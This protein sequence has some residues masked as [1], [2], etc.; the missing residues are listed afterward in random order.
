V[1]L[2]ASPIT[3]AAYDSGMQQAGT[4]RD[5]PPLDRWLL[6]AAETA[7]LADRLVGGEAAVVNSAVRELVAR[8]LIR[9]DDTHSDRHQHSMRRVRPGAADADA[10]TSQPLDALLGVFATAVKRY[11]ADGVTIRRFAALIGDR[12]ARHGFVYEEVE[13]YLEK[14]GLVTSEQVRLLGIGLWSRAALTEPGRTTCSL[15]DAWLDLFASGPPADQQTRLALLD[16][17]GSVPILFATGP[18]FD[19][20]LARGAVPTARGIDLVRLARCDRQALD[21]IG[22]LLDATAGASASDR[23]VKQH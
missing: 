9:V 1:T 2:C 20:W 7:V 3:K 8:D 6:E 13:P 22:H 21:E 4:G 15:L 16:A 23:A 12:Y 11:G 17:A 5:A 10:V 19:A 14:L 18:V